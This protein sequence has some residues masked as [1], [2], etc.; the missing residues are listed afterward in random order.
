MT[1]LP[2]RS[3]IP[4]AII[5][6]NELERLAAV[7][8]YDVL[9][10][11]P[12]G[13]FER[14]TALAARLFDVPIAIVSIVDQDRIW[15]KSHHGLD[16]DETGREAGLCASAILQGEPWVVT[17]ASVDPRTLA[18]P[19]VAGTQ[20]LRFYLGVPLT[21]ADGYNLGTLCVMDKRPRTVSDSD[22]ATLSDLAVMVVDELELRLAAHRTVE[23]EHRL[24]EQAELFSAA[25][26]TS[27][28]PPCLPVIPGLE[29]AALFR[30]AGG[31][32]VGGDFYDLFPVTPHTW[33][34]VIGDVCGKGP[35]A[36]SR[37][38][39]ARYGIRG[40]AVHGDSP[41]A[42]L[43]RVNQ[44]LLADGSLD[45]DSFCTLVLAVIEP[46]DRRFRV[47]VAVGGHPLPTLLRRDGSVGTVGRPGSIVGSFR[48]TEFFDDEVIVEPGDTLVLVTDGVQEIHTAAG[49]T[50]RTEF[51]ERLSA[52]AGMA[53]TAVIDHL[54]AAMNVNDD[55]AAI[56]ALHAMDRR[57]P[58]SALTP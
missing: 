11:P 24:R 29:I 42:T 47:R 15:F 50:G 57:A 16:V 12:D 13:A 32:Q 31:A 54:A 41:A 6:A 7:R 3:G 45:D 8:R 55:D 20:G 5:P 38:A 40:A 10:T 36:A 19:L 14:V 25:L 1:A 49:V 58:S 48:D 37:S 35:V 2:N 21:T 46:T 33:G 26:Q 9:D 22:I 39:L 23:A 30:P 44:A 56:L 17:D 4:A 53:P 34:C 28:L 43:H 27:L 52:C 18:N 51:E